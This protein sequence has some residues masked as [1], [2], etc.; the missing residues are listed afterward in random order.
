[1]KLLV[2]IPSY[3]ERLDDQG[4]LSL[5]AALRHLSGHD[6]ATMGPVERYTRHGAVHL[7][8]PYRYWNQGEDG[9]FGYNPLM[10]APGLYRMI[11]DAGYTHL[12]LYQ[13][14]AVIFDGQ[15]D[16]FS[17]WSYVGAP[18]A[19]ENT[20]DCNGIDST[21]RSRELEELGVFTY[22]GGNGGLSLRNVQDSLAVV[23]GLAEWPTVESYYR[24]VGTSEDLFWSFLAPS[25]DAGFRP[26]PFEVTLNFSWEFNPAL[27]WLLN[28]RKLPHGAHAFHR[29]SPE[30]WDNLGGVRRLALGPEAG[31]EQAPSPDPSAGLSV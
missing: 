1:M 11:H 7:E 14:D 31:P 6:W 3:Q 16:V 13:P 29:H 15:L 10:V 24:H 30:F 19:F 26:A 4:E 21:P 2:L 22:W 5:E 9:R 28:G 18:H 17:E 8:T 27:C 23:D 20:G 25:I 12:L